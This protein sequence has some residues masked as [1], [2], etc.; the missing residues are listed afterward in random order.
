MV[1]VSGFNIFGVELM[2]MAPAKMLIAWSRRSFKNL[3]LRPADKVS[4]KSN[5]PLENHI[6]RGAP[7]KAPFAAPAISFKAESQIRIGFHSFVSVPQNRSNPQESSSAII[8][9]NTSKLRVS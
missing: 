1:P 4:T 3:S 8:G 9:V 6:Q 2:M 7:Q 5:G